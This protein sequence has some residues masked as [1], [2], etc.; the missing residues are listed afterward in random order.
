MVSIIIPTC[1]P[2]GL[3]RTCIESLR[4]SSTYKNIEIICVDNI[5]DESS[6]W[7]SWLRSNCDVVVEILDAFNWSN[8]TILPRERLPANICFF[9]NDD[10]EVIQPDWLEAMLDH[11]AVT[12]SRL[13]APS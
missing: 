7:K 5:L 9:L 10:I 4:R 13:W 3:I 2:R 11:A 1:A 6:Q 12:M 8:L